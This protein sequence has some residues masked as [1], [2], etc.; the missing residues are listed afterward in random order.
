MALSRPGKRTPNSTISS[1]L[2]S[3]ELCSSCNGTGE[4]A[5]DGAIC[6]VCYGRG[7]ERDRET[8]REAQYEAADRYYKEQREREYDDTF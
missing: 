3:D 7:V 6:G 4:G 1:A 5:Y 2:S 8:I